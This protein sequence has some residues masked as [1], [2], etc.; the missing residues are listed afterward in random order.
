MAETQATISIFEYNRWD[1]EYYSS[2][3]FNKPKNPPNCNEILIITGV[4]LWNSVVGWIDLLFYI[5]SFELNN[6][7]GAPKVFNKLL[8]QT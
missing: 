6:E 3:M 2:I 4:N 1:W 7:V 5:D 8:I